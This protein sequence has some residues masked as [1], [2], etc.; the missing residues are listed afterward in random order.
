MPAIDLSQHTDLE[1]LAVVARERPEFGDVLS[2]LID[3]GRTDDEIVRIVCAANG[4][5]QAMRYAK[6]CLRALRNL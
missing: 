2:R 5:P 6:K 4:S 3:Q 1:I